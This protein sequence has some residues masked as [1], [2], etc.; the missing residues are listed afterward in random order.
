MTKPE[1]RVV[2]M[3]EC[4]DGNEL[5]DPIVGHDGKT[6]VICEQPIQAINIDRLLRIEKAAKATDSIKSML[7]LGDALMAQRVAL[8]DK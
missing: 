4:R 6:C 3:C 8:E 5:V 7:E 1:D 2:P